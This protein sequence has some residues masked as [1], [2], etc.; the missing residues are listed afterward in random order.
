MSVVLSTTIMLVD[1][2]VP[3]TQVTVSIAIMQLEVSAAFMQVKVSAANMCVTIFIEIMRVGVPVAIIQVVF[4]AVHYANY[5]F[6]CNYTGDCFC[7]SFEYVCHS[8][9]WQL[10]IPFSNWY[11]F[12]I[13]LTR[14]H[15]KTEGI[16]SNLH[17]T[18]LGNILPKLRYFVGRIL[19]MLVKRFNHYFC[20]P[21]RPIEGG[22]ILDL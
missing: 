22:V 12:F 14:K 20:F 18:A 17:F 16:T 10:Y 7:C 1:L 19:K 9:K 2:F 15:Q 13:K 21:D 6:C 11:P 5:Y 3:I 8:F 4:S